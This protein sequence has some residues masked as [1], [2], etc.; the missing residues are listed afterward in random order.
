MQIKVTNPSPFQRTKHPI[1]IG[2]PCPRGLV[3]PESAFVLNEN[4]R[5]IP[6]QATPLTHWPDKSIKW[7]LCDFLIDMEPEEQICLALKPGKPEKDARQI[8]HY[9]STDDTVEI[10]TGAAYFVLSSSILLPF[11]KVLVNARNTLDERGGKLWLKDQGNLKLPAVIEKMDIEAQGPIRFTIHLTGHFGGDNRLLFR[12]RLHFYAKTAKTCLELTLHNPRAAEHPDGIWDLGDPASF[13]FK[14]FVLSLPLDKRY[15][16]NQYFKTSQ[17]ES[18]QTCRA[19]KSLM[20]YQESSGGENWDS[21]NHRN[22]DGRV[23]MAMRGYQ[24]LQDDR[25][26]AKGDRAQ[27][28]L[29]SGSGD[30]GVSI[31][32]PRFWQEFPKALSIHEDFID[33]SFFPEKFPDLHELQGGEQKTHL[34]YLDFAASLEQAGWGLELPEATFTPATMSRSGLF[35]NIVGGKSPGPNYQEYL[36]AALEGPTGFTAKRETVDEYGWR[37][38]GDLYADHEAVHHKGDKPF[39]S[40]YNNQYDALN[41]FYRE[42][43]RTGDPRWAELAS[44]L[45]RHVLDI[46][47][48][49][50]D[51][52][53]EEYCHGLFWHTDHYLDAGLSTHRC[54]SK[55]HLRQKNPALIGGGPGA[56]HCYTTGLM[57]HY[58]LTGNPRFREEV[59]RL[60]DWCYLS[61]RGPRTI[62]ASILRAKKYLNAWRRGNQGAGIWSHFPLDRGTGNCLSAALDAFEISSDPKYL[63]LATHLIRGTVHPNDNINLRNLQNVEAWWSYTVFLVAVGKYLEKKREWNEFDDDYCYAKDSLLHYADWMVDHEYPTLTKPRILEYPNET[64]AAQDLRKSAIFY[65]AAGYAPSENRKHFMERCRFF[66]SE[67]FKEL[68]THE[69]RFLT[70]PMVLVLQNG[71][72]Q[73]L[74]ESVNPVTDGETPGGRKYGASPFRYT[75]SEVLRRISSD[76]I[77]CCV[78][79]TITREWNWLKARM[80]DK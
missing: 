30:S 56:Q 17:A 68:K 25:V 55:E 69:T 65:L 75:L 26:V 48:N 8:M 76:M 36:D 80:K 22:R 10:N 53:R 70:R 60:A 43:F 33:I 20:I 47:I 11:Q 37:N 79:T 28:V 71:W 66:L 46:D 34:L 38:F 54:V 44:D 64:W 16:A 31:I 3:K 21:P 59:L 58:L 61:L 24:I 78:D 57:I 51:E 12:A 40:H 39:V 42:Y 13:L 41:S 9:S 67:S 29:W 32:L 73:Y 50:T 74:D 52:D 63:E 45:A 72:L 18:W 7:L 4:G 19:G 49:H 35:E 2:V 15:R 5:S 14:E 23:P 27:P 77:S 62:L 6:V 1:T